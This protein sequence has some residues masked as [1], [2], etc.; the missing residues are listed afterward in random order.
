MTVATA[1]SER[2]TSQIDYEA[3]VGPGAMDQDVK[4][5]AIRDEIRERIA[6]LNESERHAASVAACE[7]LIALDPFKSANTVMLYLPMADEVDVTNVALRCFQRGISVCAPR[8][9]WETKRLTPTEIH[10]FDDAI[11]I[12]RNSVP[13]PSPGRPIPPSDIDFIVI[14]GV[15]FD[16]HG[17]RVGRGGGFYD[18]FLGC[19]GLRSRTIRCGIGFDV[20]MVDEAPSLAHDVRLDMVVTDRRAIQ[21]RAKKPV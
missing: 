10:D 21:L 6:R 9:N 4:K 2:S 3:V 19:S 13:E 17:A 14:P 1:N 7:R 15:A 5:Q 12:G 8:I 16:A 18:R 11:E 20:Q